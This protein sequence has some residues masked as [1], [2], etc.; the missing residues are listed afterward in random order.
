[1]QPSEA[2][3]RE[4]IKAKQL[5]LDYGNQVEEIIRTRMVEREGGIF[6]ASDVTKLLDLP[7]RTPPE[8]F[9]L[10]RATIKTMLDQKSPFIEKTKLHMR[11]RAIKW[12]Y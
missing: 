2:A 10:V 8:K 7:G 12:C 9:L 6:R 4:G 11:W 5:V 1:M 3:C